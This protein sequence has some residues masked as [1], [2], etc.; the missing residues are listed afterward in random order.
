[1]FYTILRGLWCNIIVL[2]GNASKEDK[3]DDV[4]DRFYKEL[5]H[6]FDNFPKYHMKI[7]VPK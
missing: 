4:K 3:I 6:A 7:S 2:K 5:E 1:M